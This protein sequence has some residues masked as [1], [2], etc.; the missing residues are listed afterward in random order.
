[1]RSVSSTLLLA[2]LTLWMATPAH[3]QIMVADDMNL[4]LTQP[5]DQKKVLWFNTDLWA[6]PLTLTAT[7]QGLG[8]DGP[9]D[10]APQGI[11]IETTPLAIGL[12]WRTASSVSIQAKVTALRPLPDWDGETHLYLRYSPDYRHW[13]EWQ[14]IDQTSSTKKP[15]TELT[16]EGAPAVPS[17]ARLPYDLLLQQHQQMTRSNDDEE[18]DVHW[19]LAR[20][21]HFFEN[22]LPFMGYIQFLFEAKIE[23]G[24]RIRSM[25]IR[26]SWGVGGLTQESRGKKG[27]K[28]QI[29]RNGPWHFKA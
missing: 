16:F 6:T 18:G 5:T 14:D 10:R 23:P 24:Q 15:G 22:C 29:D 7:A 19:I 1:M 25:D 2:V 3:C 4:D 17:V 20:E 13:S 28:K 11:S 21:P 27:E 12:A 26:Y 8:W 9:H